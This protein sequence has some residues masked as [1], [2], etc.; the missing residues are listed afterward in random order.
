MFIAFALAAALGY[1][2]QNTLMVSVYRRMDALIA[3]SLRGVALGVSMLPLL[4][5]VPAGAMSQSTTGDLVLALLGAALF[6][7]AG[8][9][10]QA[11]CFRR[12][13]VGV[14]IAVCT[15][16]MTITTVLIGMLSF[17]EVLSPGQLVCLVLLV[18]GIVGLGLSKSNPSM[19]PEYNIVAGSLRAASAGFLFGAANGFVG[20]ASRAS[21]PFI[22]G[23]FWEFIIGLIGTGLVYLRAFCCGAPVNRVSWEDFIAILKFS[24]PTLVGTG[25]YAMSLTMGPLGI[26]TAVTSTNVVG[27]TILAY[28]IYKEKLSAKE[29]LLIVLICAALVVLNL[30]Q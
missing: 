13:P 27:A 21:H 11:S 18:G 25:C 26:A 15:S 23:Y 2:L 9:W 22:A 20:A 4:F 29:F 14:G 30:Q 5:F 7:V 10:L 1:A 6:A 8:N 12:V 3:I 16:M 24:S 19:L 28:F 17:N